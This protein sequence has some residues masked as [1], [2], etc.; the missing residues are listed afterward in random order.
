[1]AKDAVRAR[2]ELSQKEESMDTELFARRVV[3]LVFK[4]DGPGRYATFGGNAL[5]AWIAYFLP[6]RL[7]DFYL[8][9]MFG[10]SKLKEDLLAESKATAAGVCPVSHRAGSRC[11]MGHQSRGDR[12]GSSSSSSNGSFMTRCPVTNP[13]AWTA[14]AASATAFAVFYVYRNPDIVDR[15]LRLLGIK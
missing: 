6:P 15:T 2:A 8:A 5:A 1:M 4:K 14:A 12:S 3:D 9:R 11:P 13:T 7:R 10:T